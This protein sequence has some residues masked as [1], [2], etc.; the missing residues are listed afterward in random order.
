M[1]VCP[2][3]K[4]YDR[5][6]L[7]MLDRDFRRFVDRS[8]WNWEFKL[9]DGVIG[10]RGTVGGNGN[11]N[12][13]NIS[14]NRK[15]TSLGVLSKVIDKFNFQIFSKHVSISKGCVK[16]TSI[17]LN[18]SSATFDFKTFCNNVTEEKISY[19]LGSYIFFSWHA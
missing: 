6:I 2:T 5:Y 16:Q 13:P 11:A 19:N 1:S 3:V 4:R 10:Q 9:K 15:Y 8:I 14:E 7:Y 12:R 17:F 18:I